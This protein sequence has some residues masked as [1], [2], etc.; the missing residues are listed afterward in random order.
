[1][2]DRLYRQ[3]YQTAL[4]ARHPLLVSHPKP[5]GDT[6]GAMLAFGATLEAAGKTHTRF[7][8][9]AVPRQYRFMAGV[10]RVTADREAV[11]RS[12]PDAVFVFDAGDLKYAG[13]EELI[14]ELGRP[15]IVNI[16]HHNSNQRYGDI[17]VVVPDASSTAE[18]VHRLLAAN[19]AIVDR[20]I[21][22]CL[23]TGLCTDT[24]NFSNPATSAS[25][26]KLGA[27]LLRRGAKFAAVQKYLFQNKS[28]AALRLWGIALSRLTVNEKYGLAFTVI[29]END[30]EHTAAKGEITEGISNFLNAVL[31]VP[32]V[33][34]LR[35]D[36]G[37][38]VRGSLRT[39]GGRDVSRLAQALGGG[40]HKKAAGFT[41]KGRLVEEQGN[42]KIKQF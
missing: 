26:L 22:T 4:A 19:G 2:M 17:N 10:E 39:N 5:D 6:L 11:G 41:I 18:V 1:M 30:L 7:C 36:A 33:L 20:E 16:D 14:R 28:A 25:A 13:I 29:T 24:S 15:K 9:D 42:W 3:A 37:G 40:G 34:V 12:S 27:E 23:L 8:A 32:T 21:A 35:E 38:L 31:N